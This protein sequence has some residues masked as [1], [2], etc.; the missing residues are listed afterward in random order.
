MRKNR[1]NYQVIKPSYKGHPGTLN[2]GTGSY[3]SG[4]LSFRRRPILRSGLASQLGFW[5]RTSPVMWN[6]MEHGNQIC[7]FVTLSSMHVFAQEVASLCSCIQKS[8]LTLLILR[9]HHC[10]G[11]LQ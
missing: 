9:S 10:T 4:G 8:P 1:S 6:G 5:P 3:L 7:N 11:R 2:S